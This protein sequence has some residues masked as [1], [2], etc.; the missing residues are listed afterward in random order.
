[1]EA[2]LIV[3]FI[4]LGTIVGFLA[5]LLGIG[6]GLVM[7]PVLTSLFVWQGLP[8]E[9]VVHLALG[10]SMASIVVTSISSMRAHHKKAGVLW[11][12]VK[13]ISP[14]ILVGAFLATFLA[15][16]LSSVF[17]AIFFA[18]FLVFASTQMFLNKKPKPSRMLPGAG[19]L[20]AAGG[21]IGS[22]SALVSIGG[23]TITVPY[24]SWHN[25]DVKKA[26]GT[27]AAIGLPISVAG[28]IG[29]MVNGLSAG[30]DIPYVFGFVYLP[31]VVLISVMSFM[32]APVGAHAAHK[33]PVPIL[34][35]VFA[36]LLLGLALK[37][38][39]SVI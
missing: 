11:D 4:V 30:L 25:V 27:S 5:G 7:V 22:I 29:Y 17:L 24:L 31:G 21:I 13:L 18:C 3:S 12:V 8:S 33:L 34:K 15:S 35:K 16:V 6:G 38:I 37:M 26:I 10:T 36:V 14:G 1:M 39:S 32:M 23:G 20:F 19:G 2:E 9:S 28:T